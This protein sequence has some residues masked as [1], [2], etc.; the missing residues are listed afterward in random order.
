MPVGAPVLRTWITGCKHSICVRGGSAT[1]YFSNG[2]REEKVGTPHE[3]VLR[4][5][6]PFLKPQRAFMGLALLIGI[7][8]TLAT[9]VQPLVLGL[10][11][12]AVTAQRAVMV[13]AILLISLFAAEALLS[14]FQGYLLART[15]ENMILGLRQTLIARLL[16][17]RVA[18]H[19]RHRSGDLMSRVGADATLLG[20]ALTFSLADAAGGVLTLL[21][22]VVLMALIDPFLLVVALV[23]V[24]LAAALVICVSGTVR[25]IGEEAQASV[26]RLSAAMERAL[27]A[28]RTI[29]ISR[30][31]GR[32][33]DRIQEEARSAYQA[34]VR[35]A[36]LQA[37]VG[38]ATSIALQ[39]SF[40]LVLGIGGARLASGAISLGDLVAFLL[41]LLY[42]AGPLAMLFASVTDLQR[43]LAAVGRI[44]EVLTLPEEPA[45][46]DSSQDGLSD[47][48][49]WQE[50]ETLVRFDSVS[51]GYSPEL[52]VLRD[53]S[54]EIPEFARTAI[55]G[56]SG[57]GKSTVF[58]LLERF[59]E[60]DSGSIV[61]DGAE[62]RSLPM[63]ELRGSIG[64][65]E[66]ESP[67]MA[68]SIRSNLTYV[69]PDATAEEL[70]EVLD[71]VSLSS[72]VEELPY[73]LDTE[74][75]DGGVLLSGGQRQR[76]AIARTLLARPRL[77][78]L[79]EATS[80]L[81][82]NNELLLRK[83]IS[84][85]SKK[86]TVVLVAHRLSTVVDADQI[87]VLDGWGR[88]SSVGKHEGLLASDALYREL[89]SSQLLG[90]K[91]GAVQTQTTQGTV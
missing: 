73:G 58:A 2:S 43:G 7:V 59:Y 50:D 25:K 72:F 8:A 85:V 11:L 30:A 70:E 63:S 37:V 84:Q 77:L 38:P 6:L 65:V 47:G 71:L 79:D 75:G 46:P 15:G 44:R 36:R 56:P 89:A 3:S 86:C 23:C 82:A 1:L 55:V 76:V 48:P 81:D 52:A 78:L 69:T 83:T 26:G 90:A 42:L 34:G 17:L 68:G 88:V 4:V 27:R 39:G 10:V 74:V 5:L 62:V 31:E 24:S 21:G 19:D 35:S 57:A 14:G 80:Q 67:V 45:Y 51:F 60:V 22:A 9:L 16:R 54:F 41:Y 20:V 13:P 40:I 64:Y 66:Q 32:E 28:I 33:T 53:V 49:S 91:D 18:E 61:F 29:K 87:V 12:D